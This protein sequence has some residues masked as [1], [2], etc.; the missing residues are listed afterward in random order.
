MTFL[1]NNFLTD[2]F[3]L[4]LDGISGLVVE[5]AVAIIIL[6]VLIRLAL[7]PI[8][9]KQRSNQAKMA[10][11]GPQIESLQKRYAN[12][13][14]KLQKK[15]QELYKKVGAQP[16]L[17]C[18][19]MLLQLFILFAFFGAMRVLQSEQTISTA[20]QAVQYGTATT[21]VHGF[22]WVHN[23]WQPDNVYSGIMPSANE[24]ISF[25]QQNSIYISPQT[26]MMLQNQGLIDFTTGTLSVVQPTYDAVMTN[27]LASNN[28]LSEA[29]NPLANGIFI[30]PTLSGA[31]MFI[32]QKFGGAL[33]NQGTNPQAQPGG[34]FMMYFFPFFSVY[35]CITSSAAF[36][37]YWTISSL[38]A[39]G[40]SRLI[41]FVQ[42]KKKEKQKI[43]V[44]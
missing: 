44:S 24:F 34:K 11:L 4:C 29:G 18:L 17:G 22:F 31:S 28:L 41:L 1:Y 3:V 26:L 42:K 19:P 10:E 7:L 33:A 20:L 32:Q 12:D 35:I 40:Q 25:L 38:Y 27:V 37:L 21:D 15:Q 43:V 39:F 30:L 16:L 13:P 6:T 8:D 14:A 36:A 2:F 5:Y 9:I 23:L